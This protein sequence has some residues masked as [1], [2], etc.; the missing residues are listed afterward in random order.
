MV[1]RL[2]HDA[3]KILCRTRTFLLRKNL[4][5]PWTPCFTVIPGEEPPIRTCKHKSHLVKVMCLTATARPRKNPVN[6]EWWDGKVGTWF[7][8]EKVAAARTSKNRPAGTLE[9]KTVKVTKEVTVDMILTNL[10]PA[11]EAKWPQFTRKLVRIQQDNATPHP[12]P[13]SDERI[14]V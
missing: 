8:V 14:N 4:F 12:R 6:G 1:S 2:W 5:V 9:T 11:I 3:G 13:G 10:L 7:F